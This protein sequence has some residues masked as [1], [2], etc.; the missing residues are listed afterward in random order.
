MKPPSKFPKIGL[1]PTVFNRIETEIA[2]RTQRGE[3]TIALHIGDTFLPLPEPLTTPVQDEDNL[4]GSRLNRYGDTFGEAALRELLRDKVLNRNR[5]PVTGIDCIQ[6]TDG[7][8][9]ALAAG[10]SRLLEPGAEVLVLS[11]YWTIL[12]VVAS[13]TRIKLVEVPYFD[14]LE[15]GDGFDPVNQLEKYVSQ[16]TAALY[17]NTPSNPTGMLLDMVQLEAISRFA[18]KHDLWVFSDE[19][20]EDFIW[21]GEEHISIGSLP[22]MFE[23]TVSVYTFSK[24]FGAS[25]LRLGYAVAPA[26]VV[27]ELNRGVVGSY[28]QTARNN[29]LLAWRGM[30]HF[31]DCVAPL[32]DSYRETW[33]ETKE[34]L[35]LKSLPCVGGFYIFVWLGD[36][37][38]GIPSDRKITAMLDAGVVMSPGESFGNDYDGWARLCFTVVPPDE[39]RQAVDLL[40]RLAI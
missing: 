33:R 5:L 40:N 18:K 22:G 24:C 14:L 27:A 21:T 2:R 32:R 12:R 36:S 25:G 26:P 15:S 30:Q 7:A 3:K 34:N 35:E 11:P 16:H 4:F 29:Q 20:Y 8:T 19:A 37:W 13:Q 6:V 38:K 17:V 10:F 31:E 39:M 23:R 1:P 28:Y 9:G